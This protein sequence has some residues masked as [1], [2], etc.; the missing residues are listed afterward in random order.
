M[1]GSSWMREKQVPCCRVVKGVR[2]LLQNKYLY[3]K[4]NRIGGR[5][6]RTKIMPVQTNSLRD[7]SSSPCTPQPPL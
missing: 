2:Q 7:C 5:C 1:A 3:G 4:Y 6:R